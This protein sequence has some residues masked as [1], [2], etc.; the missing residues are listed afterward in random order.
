[1]S[2]FDCLPRHGLFSLGGFLA[3]YWHPAYQLLPWALTSA[4]L[5][6]AAMWDRWS[7]GGPVDYVVLGLGAYELMLGLLEEQTEREPHSDGRNLQTEDVRE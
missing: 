2:P 6:V 7:R 4:S 5:T 3:R 1:M